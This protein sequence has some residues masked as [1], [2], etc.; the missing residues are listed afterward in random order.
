MKSILITGAAGFIGSNFADKYRDEFPDS[1]I[2]I[3]DKLTYAANLDNLKDAISKGAIFIKGDI[4][5]REIV[6]S[7]LATH[8]IDYVVNFAAESHVD[9]SIENP[10]VFI[11]TNVVGTFN[12]VDEC[13]KYYNILPQ[14]RQSKFR[15]LHIST[16]EVYGHLGFDDPKFNED[17]PYRPNSPYSASKASSDMIVRSYNQT[18][19]LPAIITNCSNNYGP[20][21]HQEKLIPTIIRSCLKQQS[22]PIYGD[23]KNIR[24]WIYV[25]D[26]SRGVILALHK[27]NIGETYCIGANCEKNNLEI[28]ETI[29]AIMDKKYSLPNGKKYSS[30]ITF[31]K[32]RPGHDRRYAIDATKITKLGFSPSRDFLVNM[33]LTTDE[34]MRR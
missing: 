12:L 8:Q 16:D 26:H 34:L 27:G 31:V 1:K 11:E 10:S 28:A 4:G 29:C 5:D 22:I 33:E 13:L 7:I 15:F 14:D 25:D 17:S 9:N 3:L 18:Y 23:G 19:G 6:S 20:R 32:D 24:D 30:L 2:V 21:Q